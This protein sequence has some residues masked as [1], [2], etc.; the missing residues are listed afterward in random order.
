VAVAFSL[1]VTTSTAA[2][3]S[4]DR[5]KFVVAVDIGHSPTRPGATS[6]R[7]TPELSFNQMLA[8]RILAELHARGFTQSFIVQ[9]PG[10][11]LDLVSR[12][13]RANRRHAD[14]FLSV[15]H[16]SVQPRYLTRWFYNGEPHQFSDRFHGYSIFYSERNNAAAASRE[17]C[18]LLGEALRAHGLTPSLHHA[19]KIPGENRDLVDPNLGIYRFDDLVVLHTAR[20]PAALLEGG[21]IVNRDEE[22]RIGDPDYQQKLSDSVVEAVQAFCANRLSPP[23]VH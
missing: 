15:H 4:C 1:L 8:D 3:A 5:A 21:V 20:M 11:S 23:A 6:A 13:E 16:D 14:L 2:V 19:E 7:G 12:T 18:R 22:I 17:F 9:D 10:E